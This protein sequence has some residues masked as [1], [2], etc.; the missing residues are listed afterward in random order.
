MAD[1]LPMPGATFR[2]K[3]AEATAPEDALKGALNAGLLDVAIVGRTI[4][5]DITV[6]GSQPDSDAA[7][8]LLTRGITFLAGAQQIAPDEDEE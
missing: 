2:A 6:F 1:I 8:G 3:P 7:I 4:S 5:G